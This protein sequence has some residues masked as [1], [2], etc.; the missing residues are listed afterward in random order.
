[1]TPVSASWKVNWFW[2]ALKDKFSA[3]LIWIGL[4]VVEGLSRLLDVHDTR[5]NIGDNNIGAGELQWHHKGGKR[6]SRLVW[7]Q[8]NRFICG[9]QP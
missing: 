2:E 5:N 3:V 8:H 6:Y 9:L 1:M 7:L 4:S